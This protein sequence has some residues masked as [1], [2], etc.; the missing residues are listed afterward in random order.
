MSRTGRWACVFAL[1]SVACA[2]PGA[3]VTR[4]LDGALCHG[5]PPAGIGPLLQPRATIVLGDLPGTR[6]LPEIVGHIVC[7]MAMPGTRVRLVLELP[8]SERERVAAFVHSKGDHDDRTALVRGPF[9]LDERQIGATTAM[10]ALLERVR[11]WTAAGADIEVV[12]A[13]EWIRARGDDRATVALVD[14]RRP[15][16]ATAVTLRVAAGGGDRW[17]CPKGQ[18]CGPRPVPGAGDGFEPRV[19]WDDVPRGW[20][21]VLWIGVV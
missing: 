17:R 6:E 14:P 21:G 11:E 4:P 5:E 3:R 18:R 8:P 7:R 10:L 9:W 2:A 15:L 1:S 19:R 16:A 20:D 12:P 13:S